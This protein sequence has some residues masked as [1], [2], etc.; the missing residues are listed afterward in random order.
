MLYVLLFT[1]N[2]SCFL[3]AQQVPQ[4]RFYRHTIQYT[5]FNPDIV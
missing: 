5:P 1:V 2:I 3:I 4:G